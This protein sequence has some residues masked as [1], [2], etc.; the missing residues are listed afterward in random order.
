[1]TAPGQIL[2]IGGNGTVGRHV[3]AGLLRQG[4]RARALV[5]SRARATAIEGTGLPMVVGDLAEPA[6]L[7]AA[8]EGVGRVFL[9]SSPSP[10]TAE[11]HGNLIERARRAGARHVVRVSALGASRTSP[12]ELLRGHG[13]AEELLESSG[14]GFTHLRPAWF[15]QNLLAYAPWIAAHGE[16][17]VP[18]G[19]GTLAMIDARD[20]ARVAVAALT[21]DGHE[22]RTY[23]LTG[24]EALDFTGVAAGLS[25]VLGRP[26]RHRQLA[27]QEGRRQMVAG[28]MP[29]WLADSLL[30]LFTHA[31][32]DPPAEVTGDVE[33]V[34]GA[35][36]TPLA[37]FARDHVAE[38]AGHESATG[39]E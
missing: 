36:A 21:A 1:M 16:L 20:V 10:R 9:L 35:P 2:I 30:A 23:R 5:R 11:L 19:R 31:P 17:A 14:L 6:S 32:V 15:M 38:L 3:V 34:T 28:G 7:D 8:L 37:T 4:A 22:G 25:E 24:P 13:E 26:V 39:S 12:G 18:I 27:P 29:E 33:A